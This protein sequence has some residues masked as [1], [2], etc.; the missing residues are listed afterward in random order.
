[1]VNIISLRT[2]GAFGKQFSELFLASTAAA[3]LRGPTGTI[4]NPKDYLFENFPTCKTPDFTG[5]LFIFVACAL[6]MQQHV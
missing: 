6:L 1:L 3:V 2:V 4:N 5:F